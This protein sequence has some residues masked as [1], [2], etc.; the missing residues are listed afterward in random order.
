MK[1]FKEVEHTADVA[2][3]AKGAAIG[4]L[5]QN[6]AHGMFSLL[7]DTANVQPKKDVT[8]D[9]TA[10]NKEELLVVFLN[11]ILYQYET[12]KIVFNKCSIFFISDTRAVALCKGEKINAS[13]SIL[14]EIKAATYHHLKIQKSGKFWE[15]QIIF[16]V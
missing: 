2:V 5:F 11:E 8:I 16:D 1:P 10:K 3:E 9:V 14:R 12:R 7:A 6:A 4:E 13:H 15:A